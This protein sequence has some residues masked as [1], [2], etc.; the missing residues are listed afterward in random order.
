MHSKIKSTPWLLFLCLSLWL[1]GACAAPT[2]KGG[3]LSASTGPVTGIPIVAAENF[4]GDLFKQIGG[5]YVSVTSVLSDP[6]VDPHQYESSVQNAITISNA[7]IVIE[8]G[9]G[10]DTWMDKLLAASPNADRVVL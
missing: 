9:G 5:A 8:N 2:P 6:N 3:N 1:V 7:S 10:Y 4:Y